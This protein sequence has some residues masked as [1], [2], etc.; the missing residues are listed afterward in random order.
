[1]HVFVDVNKAMAAHGLYATKQHEPVD[2]WN[3]VSQNLS[4]PWYQSMRYAVKAL[5]ASL[6]LNRDADT[7]NC[8]L[9]IYTCR[10]AYCTDNE[11]G[12]KIQVT[13]NILYEKVGDI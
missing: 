1:M 3:E 4:R 12:Q 13:K 7:L 8:T 6:W 11:T 5:E 9:Q 2:L 10:S